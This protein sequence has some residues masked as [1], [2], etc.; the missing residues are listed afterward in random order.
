MKLVV[1]SKECDEQKKEGNNKEHAAAADVPDVTVARSTADLFLPVALPFKRARPGTAYKRRNNWKKL[2]QLLQQPEAAGAADT[3]VPSP[4]AP[5]C[6]NPTSPTMHE[7]CRREE[8]CRKLE[9]THPSH[10]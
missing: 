10:A 6:R 9:S 5:T 7:C 3:D 8:Q 2:K 4:A 1:K